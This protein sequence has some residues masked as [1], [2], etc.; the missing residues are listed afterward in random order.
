LPES[1]SIDKPPDT[2]PETRTFWRISN[3][4][5]LS[6]R[7]GFRTPGRWHAAGSRI[8]Y[9]ADSPASAIL[10]TLVHMELS[11]ATFPERYKLLEVAV[12]ADCRW[13]QIDVPKGNDWKSDFDLTRRLGSEWLHSL[14]SALAWVPSALAPQTRNVLLNPAHADAA[15]ILIVS[16]RWERFDPRLLRIGGR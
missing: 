2:G 14:G 11:E 8:V 13:V 5:D 3:Y 10:E 6:G 4:S 12:P 15:R 9:L 1:G 16:E 7:G